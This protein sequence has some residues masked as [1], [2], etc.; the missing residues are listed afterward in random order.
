SIPPNL[1]SA[2]PK[3]C[4]SSAAPGPRHGHSAGSAGITSTARSRSGR[5]DPNDP[6]IVY[7]VAQDHPLAMKF[8]GTIEWSY[9]PA[10]GETGKML[11]DPTARKNFDTAPFDRS[12]GPAL[13]EEMA[14]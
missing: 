4:I 5:G 14:S 6:D 2:L 7:G 3:Q 12:T 10:G 8:A 1:A 11:V 13:S 9:M